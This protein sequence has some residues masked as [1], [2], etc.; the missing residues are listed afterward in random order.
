M[1]FCKFVL[2]V[3]FSEWMLLSIAYVLLNDIKGKLWFEGTCPS[4]FPLSDNNTWLKPA[5]IT[6]VIII[7]KR[8]IKHLVLLKENRNIHRTCLLGVQNFQELEVQGWESWYL[9]LVSVSYQSCGG[10]TAN[11]AAAVV[12]IM[13]TLSS[14]LH[15]QSASSLF[16][17]YVLKSNIHAKWWHII[18]AQIA[19]C[20]QS[21]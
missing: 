21:D 9:C 20:S 8:F 1:W 15:L 10:E 13:H 6:L 12:A 19:E 16:F 17:N 5:T 4:W 3:L 11:Q 14:D 7:I 2:I 18:N